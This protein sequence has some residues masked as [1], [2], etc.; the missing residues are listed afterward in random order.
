MAAEAEQVSYG[1][2][3][4]KMDRPIVSYPKRNIEPSDCHVHLGKATLLHST[5]KRIPLRATADDM[6]DIGSCIH[7]IFCVLDQ[8]GEAVV[9]RI[10][11]GYKLVDKLPERE[12]IVDAWKNLVSYLQSHYGAAKRTYHELGFKQWL[13]GQV[14]TGSMDYVYETADGVVVVDFKTYPGSD[15]CVTDPENKHYAGVYKDQLDCYDRA[16]N[17]QGLKVLDRL[18]YYPVRGLMVQVE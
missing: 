7:D 2:P 16:L 17:A 3:V 6:T 12:G 15:A 11:D 18:I 14:V 10:V 4:L 8:A 1:C 9:D 5:G 13:D